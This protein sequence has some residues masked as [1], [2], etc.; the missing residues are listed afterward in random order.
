MS[1]KARCV[2]CHY[3]D[4]VLTLAGAQ[5]VASA[6]SSIGVEMNPTE[7]NL[8]TEPLGRT[9]YMPVLFVGH[10]SPMNDIEENEFV[11]VFRER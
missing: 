4:H 2:T 9:G 8:W 3:F 7:Q 10:G 5:A 1:G 11:K 6:S